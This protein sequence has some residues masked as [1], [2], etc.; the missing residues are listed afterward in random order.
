MKVV[1]RKFDTPVVVNGAVAQAGDNGSVSL[2][3]ANYSDYTAVWQTMRKFT[4]ERDSDTLDEIWSVQH[5]P[6]Y[7]RG[8][9][10]RTSTPEPGGIPVLDIDRGGLI[11]YHGPGQAVLYL[12]LDLKRLGIGV[13][14]LVNGIEQ[15]VIDLCSVFDVSAQR[16]DNA[17][18]VYV[19]GAKLASLGLRVRNG[20]TY[21]G[22]ALNVDMDLEPFDRIVPCGL[23]GVEA[24]QLRD[25]G[26]C[27]SVE[28]VAAG[29][30]DRIALRFG[31]EVVTEQG[32]GAPSQTFSSPEPSAQPTHGQGNGTVML[33]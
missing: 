5:A 12:M 13:R 22:L 33:S 19:G 32:F 29:L 14:S 25:L 23:D 15:S 8:Q 7:T 16:R 26:V 31:Y 6:I 18:G 28:D 2:D 10:D 9:R 3:E 11:T 21:H 20:R 24:T 27:V 30:L 1:Y 17:P 4:L